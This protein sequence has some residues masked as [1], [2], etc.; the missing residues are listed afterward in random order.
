M[1]R[2]FT[3]EKIRRLRP[4]LN[5]PTWVPEASMLTSRAP[6]PLIIRLLRIIFH[7]TGNSAQLCQNFGISGRFEP[8]NPTPWVHHCPGL[9]MKTTGQYFKFESSW[10]RMQPHRLWR[11]WVTA[12]CVRAATRLLDKYVTRLEHR[13]KLSMPSL[14]TTCYSG[15]YSECSTFMHNPHL[16]SSKSSVTRGMIQGIKTCV[17]VSITKKKR[18][19][20]GGE[21]RYKYD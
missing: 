5:P 6:K 21:E 3:P 10:D 18:F 2:I 13:I 11:H 1:L 16:T 14:V 15:A 4:G 8:P 7:G 12:V 19:G 17:F 20:R 9:T